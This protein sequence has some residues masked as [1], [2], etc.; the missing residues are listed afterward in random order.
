MM[1]VKECIDKI[2]DNNDIKKK[3]A[4]WFYKIFSDDYE[5]V[6]AYA[7]TIKYTDK[8]PISQDAQIE[9][10]NELL[11]YD[12]V[13]PE[14]K[15]LIFEMMNAVDP[16]KDYLVDMGLLFK[17]LYSNID[18]TSCDISEDVIRCFTLRE[19]IGSELIESDIDKLL[20]DYMN[21]F[22]NIKTEII[23]DYININKVTIF[24]SIENIVYKSS[25]IFLMEQIKLIH[26]EIL[27]WR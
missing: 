14:I 2:Y 15:Q 17:V 13:T 21:L 18:V 9:V 8:I 24:E 6:V 26:N 22:Y 5:L 20:S 11:R 12:F 3:K 1:N 16:Y 23:K 7:I 25:N 27:N 10:C 19:S 4:L